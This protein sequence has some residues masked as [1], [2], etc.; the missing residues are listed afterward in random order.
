MSGYL[1]DS[2]ILINSN[3]NY[4]QQF[5]PIVWQFYL[6]MP[7]FYMIDRVYDE[8]LTK[9]DDLK[10]WTKQNF[11]THKILADTCIA[12]YTQVVKYLTDSNLWT[13]AG[14]QQWKDDPSKADPWLIACAMKNSYT[15]ITD[16]NDT[17]P[18]GKPTDNEPK[19]P[20]VAKHFG[21]PTISF[22]SF[23]DR[24]HFIAS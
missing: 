1:V 23:L 4:R 20:F 3:R 5:F 7:N 18:N 22:W 11:A 21:V 19:I 12:E 13:A 15:I 6:N 24:S 2:N 10:K 17:G 16:E 14:A 8:L 9:D